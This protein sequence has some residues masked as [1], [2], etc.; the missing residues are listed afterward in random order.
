MYCEE[1]EKMGKNRNKTNKINNNQ[2]KNK[3]DY[4]T[5]IVTALITG[6]ISFAGNYMILNRQLEQETVKRDYEVKKSIYTSFLDKINQKD[7]LLIQELLVIGSLSRQ[8][9]TDS[10]IR[11]LEDKIFEFHSK[12][13]WMEIYSKLNLYLNNLNLVSNPKIKMY[14]KDIINVI[15]YRKDLIDYEKYPSDFRKKGLDWI[16]SEGGEMVENYGSNGQLSNDVW[17][18]MMM[19]SEILDILIEEMSEDLNK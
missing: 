2:K 1:G 8:I 12:Y 3:T 11:V 19:A 6:G 14:V 17:Y 4:L 13:Q 10:S 5:I 15:S 16:A 7:D 18:S 9:D